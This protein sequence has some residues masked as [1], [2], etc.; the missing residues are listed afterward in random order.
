MG[1]V[2]VLIGMA[3]MLFW[4][5]SLLIAS[6]QQDETKVIVIQRILSFAVFLAFV[7]I[8]LRW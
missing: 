7:V 3:I 5:S 1:E 6:F 2:L 8:L 4:G